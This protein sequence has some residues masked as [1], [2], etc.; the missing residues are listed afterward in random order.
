MIP[1]SNDVH[2]ML[3]ESSGRF[4]LKRGNPVDC[5]NMNILYN[6]TG[7]PSSSGEIDQRISSSCTFI[8]NEGPMLSQEILRHALS[9]KMKVPLS[10]GEIDQRISSSCT[11]IR[12][13]GPSNNVF[14]FWF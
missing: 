8:R 12:N 1:S 11:F 6:P 3:D 4:H 14:L 9:Y 5:V 2:H 7:H 10:S 13:E